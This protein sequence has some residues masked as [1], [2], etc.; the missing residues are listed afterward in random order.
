MIDVAT[1][2]L[3]T[4][5]RKVNNLFCEFL[6]PGGNVFDKFIR[7][8]L[9]IGARQEHDLGDIEPSLLHRE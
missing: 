1:V 9:S 5:N 6:N 7:V 2:K 8:L 4:L 3:V